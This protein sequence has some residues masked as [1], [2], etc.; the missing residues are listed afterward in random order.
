[1]RSFSLDVKM[2]KNIL[3][4]GLEYTGA[5]IPDVRT[6]TLGLCRATTCNE[7]AAFALYEYDAC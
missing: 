3:L 7:K 2:T 1:M 5:A 4:V 6:E